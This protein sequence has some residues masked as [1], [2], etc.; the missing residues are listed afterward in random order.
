MVG[1]AL[2][3]VR[4]LR[5]RVLL[6]L[7]QGRGG[8][9]DGLP[10][11][12]SPVEHEVLQVGVHTGCP[13]GR[14]V[15]EGG[16]AVAAPEAGPASA[17]VVVVVMGARPVVVV[18]RQRSVAGAHQVRRHLGWVLA[19]KWGGDGDALFIQKILHIFFSSSRLRRNLCTCCSKRTK[20][21]VFS[22]TTIAF[23]SLR[24]G[25]SNKC[26]CLQ[27]SVRKELE[28]EMRKKERSPPYSS[29]EEG[30]GKRGEEKEERASLLSDRPKKGR[31]F[32]LPFSSSSSSS[33]VL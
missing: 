18:V 32:Q 24:F 33:S 26:L 3:Q 28:R 16:E 14:R 12:A 7:L 6:L 19:V 9:G 20:R 25:L 15:G 4:V 5:V 31:Q 17:V 22:L 11:V 13:E 8:G 1:R 30:R 2:Q 10:V 29:D 23:S 21:K 27:L